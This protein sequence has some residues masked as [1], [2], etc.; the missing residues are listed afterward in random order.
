MKFNQKTFGNNDAVSLIE[1][2]LTESK[3]HKKQ[4]VAKKFL[5][6]IPW[7]LH[8]RAKSAAAYAGV[9]LHDYIISAIKT[10]TRKSN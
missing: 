3:P 2:T 10:V 4:K 1:S 5:L 6:D 9:T 8:V 7:D